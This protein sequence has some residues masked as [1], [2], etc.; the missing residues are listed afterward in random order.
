MESNERPEIP[1]KGETSD[2]LSLPSGGNDKWWLIEGNNRRNNNDEEKV[3]DTTLTA[4][5]QGCSVHVSGDGA[6]RVNMYVWSK[7]V[8]VTDNVRQQQRQ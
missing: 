3:E 2:T 8:V 5:V 7:V 4:T 1:D 6:C